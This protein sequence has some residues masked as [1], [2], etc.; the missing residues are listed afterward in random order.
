MSSVT[1]RK[2]GKENA[3]GLKPLIYLIKKYISR[4]KIDKHL[5]LK[6]GHML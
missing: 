6:L 3:V 2:H 5:K 4:V 1:S